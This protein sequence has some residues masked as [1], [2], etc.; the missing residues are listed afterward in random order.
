MVIVSPNFITPSESNDFINFIDNNSDNVTH[1]NENYW[2]NGINIKNNIDTFSFF[3]RIN[4]ESYSPHL[5]RIHKIDRYN[6]TPEVAHYDDTPFSFIIFL[7]DNFIGGEINFKGIV[8]KPIS[9]SIV[10][11]TKDAIHSIKK[12]QEGTRYT[13]V[14]FL[15]KPIKFD[16]KESLL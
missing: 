9:N 2:Y 5:L 3:K 14:G 7:N 4:I 6:S 13:L 1:F 10:Y 15:N 8:V 16:R 11:F 12:V